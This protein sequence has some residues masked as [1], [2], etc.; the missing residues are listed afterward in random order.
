MLASCAQTGVIVASLDHGNLW[1][2][3]FRPPCMW[4]HIFEVTFPEHAPPLPEHVLWAMVGWALFHQHLSFAVGL[5]LGF[6]G[7]LRTGELFSLKSRHV[8][9]HSTGRK[10]LISLGFTKGGKRAGAAES[11]IVGYEVLCTMF[12]KAGFFNHFSYTFTS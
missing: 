11:V 5:L 2:A 1:V 9:F 3:G 8:Q 4:T 6:Y 12:E 10:I 7:M